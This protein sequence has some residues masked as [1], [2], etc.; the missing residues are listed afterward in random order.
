MQQ[1]GQAKEQEVV[2]HLAGNHSGLLKVRGT[3]QSSTDR[4]VVKQPLDV[5]HLEDQGQERE[6]QPHVE[7]LELVV[8]VLGLA[9][10]KAQEGEGVHHVLV[11]CLIIAVDVV[12]HL[13]VVSPHEGGASNQVVSQAQRVVHNGVGGHGSVVPAVLDGQADPGARKAQQEGGGGVGVSCIQAVCNAC[14]GEDGQCSTLTTRAVSALDLLPLENL[15]AD[16]LPDGVVDVRII[17]VGGAWHGINGEALQ[18]GQ[19]LEHANSHIWP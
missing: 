18:H 9:G 15:L 13:V 11:Q 12:G 8:P 10:V 17:G 5:A 4:A 14:I 7:V 16:T 19:T 6:G 2:R 1:P 3:V